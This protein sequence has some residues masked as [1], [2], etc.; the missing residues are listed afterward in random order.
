MSKS[1]KIDINQMFIK[2]HKQAIRTANKTAA[3]KGTSLV[4]RE[5]FKVK[6]VKP[7]VKYVGFEAIEPCKKKKISSAKKSDSKK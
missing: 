5:G 2:A 1:K 7:N 6:M 3:R 4:S